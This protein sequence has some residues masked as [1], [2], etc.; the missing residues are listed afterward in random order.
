MHD[1]SH[2]LQTKVCNIESLIKINWIAF[3]FFTHLLQDLINKFPGY[4]VLKF[5]VKLFESASYLDMCYWIALKF[6]ITFFITFCMQYSIPTIFSKIINL[7]TFYR[8]WTLNFVL[9]LKIVTS[10][11]ITVDLSMVGMTVGEPN[12]ATTCLLKINFEK[13]S[14]LKICFITSFC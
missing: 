7:L 2:P 8:I 6:I 9:H 4:F 3:I 1:R 11:I 5:L 10:L 14:V 12:R 13:R